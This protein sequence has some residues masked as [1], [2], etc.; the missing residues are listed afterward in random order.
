MALSSSNILPSQGSFAPINKKSTN[1]VEG[2]SFSSIIKDVNQMEPASKDEKFIQGSKE[3]E[4]AEQLEEAIK[5]LLQEEKES[6]DEDTY[7]IITNEISNI[8]NV[9]ATQILSILGTFETNIDTT[10]LLKG[11]LT[12]PV[13]ENMDTS[14][15]LK[16]LLANVSTE[17][18]N[19]LKEKQGTLDVATVLQNFLEKLQKNES[20]LTKDVKNTVIN[21]QDIQR[22]LK[23]ASSNSTNSTEQTVNTMAKETSK[24]VNLLGSFTNDSQGESQAQESSV[25][26]DLLNILKP[27]TNG[28]FAIFVSG[29]GKKANTEAFVREL[30]DVM[31]KGSL[32]NTNSMKKLTIRLFPENL[33]SIRIELIQKDSNIVARIL[34]SNGKTKDLIDSSL[35]LLQHLLQQNQVSIGKIE[36][37]QS[38][39]FM[40]EKE[41][42]EQDDQKQDKEKNSDSHAN[43]SFEDLLLERVE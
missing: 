23:D 28:Q 5:K 14:A 27:T 7:T 20:S 8:I 36:T 29:E 13:D 25:K 9:L 26:Q 2:D 19:L 39:A 31:T 38:F 1:R 3:K 40:Q 16:E 22:M 18:S 42:K 24:V 6:L 17:T 41:K 15:I 30:Y 37:S 10:N 21:L 43:I 34:T 11:L 33:G 35:P 32:Q 12:N 4:I